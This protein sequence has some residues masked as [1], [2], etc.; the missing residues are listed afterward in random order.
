MRTFRKQSQKSKVR[1]LRPMLEG[2]ESRLTPSTFN[3]NTFL[4]TVAVNLQKGTDASGHVSLRSAIMA[5]DANPSSN[6]IVLPS[7]TFKLTIPATGNDGSANGDLDIAANLAIQGSA[8]GQTVIDGNSLD[9]VFH[10]L[11]GNVAM[12]HIVIE[13]GRAVA[14]GEVS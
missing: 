11:S 6:T 5:A 9:R 7:G 1:R 13:H 10:V 14:A 4:D 12:S 3:V 8:T 2:L